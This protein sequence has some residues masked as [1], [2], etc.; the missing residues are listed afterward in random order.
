MNS[1]TESVLE[2]F[3]SDYHFRLAASTLE[4]YEREIRVFYSFVSKSFREVRPSDIRGWLSHLQ[5]LNQKPATINLKLTVLRRFYVYTMEEGLYNKDP[6]SQVEFLKQEDRLPEYLTQEQLE[7]L[8]NLVANSPRERAIIETLYT[9]GIRKGELVDL[10]QTDIVW[11]KGIIHIRK[12]KG[13][14]DRIVLFNQDCKE[15]IRAY[16]DTRKDDL[17]NLFLNSK[18][19][20]VQPRTLGK[21][22]QKYSKRLGFRVTVHM[23]RHTFASHLVQKGMPLVYIQDLLGHDNIEVTQNY[24]R[25]YD[26][27][28][29]E[30]YDYYL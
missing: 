4:V 20:P 18:G 21:T 13:E 23:L 14:K 28:R 9:T 24:A 22:F 27:A 7:A 19:N 2:Q 15:R 10:K 8:R 11:E 5:T 29:K 30:K 6:A 25:L 26:Q 16:L 3:L 1:E 17:P 12:G